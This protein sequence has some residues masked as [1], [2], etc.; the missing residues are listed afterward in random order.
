MTKATDTLSPETARKLRAARR[1]REAAIRK[2]DLA[3]LEAVAAGASLRAIGAEVG[4][5][6]EGVRRIVRA[7]REEA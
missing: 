5:T 1:A 7:E 4:L 3:I 2:R 6:H